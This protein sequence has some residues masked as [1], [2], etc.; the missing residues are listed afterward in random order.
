MRRLLV[1]AAVLA[2]AALVAGTLLLGR[3]RT[4]PGLLEGEEVLAG[5]SAPVEVLY[6]S[7]GIPHIFAASVEDAYRAQGRLHVHDRLWQM[8]FFRRVARGRLSEILGEAALPSDRFLRTLGMHRV[9]ARA[10]RTLDPDTR[11]LLEAY[12]EGVNA[13]IEGWSGLLPPEFLVLRFRPEPFT[14]EDLLAIERIMAWDLTQY[15]E[16]LIHTEAYEA[17][18]PE[19]FVRVREAFPEGGTTI[20]GGE[21]GLA[22]PAAGERADADEIGAL[23]GLPLAELARAARIPDELRPMLRAV[24]AVHASN[25]WVVGGERSA[26]GKPLLANDMHLALTRPAL[27]YLVGLH[28]PGYDVVGMSIPGAPAVLGWMPGRRRR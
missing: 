1:A 9:A 12:L 6:D 26:S 19:G 28:A 25:A 22:F 13:A 4:G 21:R 23:A 5:L 18:G 8:E 15:D 20:L 14:L 2:V 24:S 10:V 7:V 11:R 17:L 16:D 27:W 3:V